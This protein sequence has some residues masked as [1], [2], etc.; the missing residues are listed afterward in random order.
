MAL[1]LRA[2]I[3]LGWK[4]FPETNTLAYYKLFKLIA[5][6]YLAVLAMMTM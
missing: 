3:R 1:A 6:V 2:N 5:K 4:G